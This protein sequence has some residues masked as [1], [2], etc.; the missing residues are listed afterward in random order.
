MIIFERKNIITVPDEFYHQASLDELVTLINK[1][2]SQFTDY[3]KLRYREENLECDS[4]FS[5]KILSEV[6]RANDEL[7][8][9]LLLI[10]RHPEWKIYIPR[11]TCETE[12]TPKNCVALAHEVYH[13]LRCEGSIVRKAA[14]IE[15]IKGELALSS[16]E[17]RRET[18]L[19]RLS[20]VKY[21]PEEEY[22]DYDQVEEVRKHFLKLTALE[23]RCFSRSLTSDEWYELK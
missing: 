9:H 2:I 21:F 1:I 6:E 13:E 20:E 11:N 12:V 15:V 3:L 4:E 16:H 22:F 8:D 18:G 10:G 5:E 7:L 23:P 19:L 14:H 17:V